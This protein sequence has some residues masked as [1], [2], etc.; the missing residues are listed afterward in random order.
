MP[1]LPNLLLGITMFSLH[2]W[3]NLLLAFVVLAIALLAINH[4][5]IS[6]IRKIRASRLRARALSLMQTI[7]P[8]IGEV[9]SRADSNLF[10]LFK[11]RANLE[12]V[13]RKADLLFDI[14]QQELSGF[15]TVLSTCVARYESGIL[16]RQEQS[17]L[18][19]AAER[20]IREMTELS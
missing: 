7:T 11:L 15:L 9:L 8:M 4:S 6:F 14:E 17:E 16:T 5:K 3:A 13:A 18:S 2:F 1:P 12:L 20:V 10:P 19:L